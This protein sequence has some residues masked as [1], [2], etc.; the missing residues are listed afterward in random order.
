M[1]ISIIVAMD[2][3]RGIGKNNKLP[4]NLPEDLRRFKKITSG[5]AVIMGRNTFE[6]I[7]KPLEN[8][9]NIV[10]TNNK[11]S[12]KNS[13]VFLCDS[14][15]SVLDSC[16]FLDEI[17]IIGGENVYQ[18]FVG[19][20]DKIYATII[21]KDFECD[22]FFPLFEENLYEC[23]DIERHEGYQYKTLLKNI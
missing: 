13:H 17:F 16:K 1:K 18:Q 20:A 4:W 2:N 5:H 23:I 19:M 7:G 9:F 21:N 12:I 3:Y 15:E 14:V 10:L 11:K 8:R 22:T 6:S